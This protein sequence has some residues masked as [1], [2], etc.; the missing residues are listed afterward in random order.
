MYKKLIKGKLQVFQFECFWLICNR[1]FNLNCFIQ[2]K[3]YVGKMLLGK[4]RGRNSG[5]FTRCLTQVLCYFFI[6]ALLQ[7]FWFF[8][9]AVLTVAKWLQQLGD[10]HLY[11]THLYKSPVLNSETI[12]TNMMVSRIPN[13]LLYS[14]IY[15]FFFLPYIL[16]LNQDYWLSI[17]WY[18]RGGEVVLI[19][20]CF[21]GLTFVR[22]VRPTETTWPS[23]NERRMKWT[24]WRQESTL[25]QH[26]K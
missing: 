16:A 14:T 21:S 7:V 4:S 1:K 11:T 13:I 20:L 22:R 2:W 6:P 17:V 25:I 23:H 26:R 8:F 15:S 3:K 9:Q 18:C 19:G 24:L 10:L 12:Q 5:S